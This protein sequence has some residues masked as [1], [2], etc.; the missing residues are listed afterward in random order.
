M[1]APTGTRLEVTE[2]YVKRVE[3]IVR[4]VVK[5]ADLGAIVSNIGVTPDLSAL[6]T[7]NSAMHTGF[8]EVGLQE[9]HKIGS[10]VYMD[11][12]RKR[13]AQEM[14]ELRTYFQSGGLVDSVLNQ[15]VPAPIDVQV[16]GSNMQ[17]ADNIA[18]DL[19]R[20]FQALPGI[21][22]VYIPQ[23]MDYPALQVNVNRERAAELG[24]DPKEVIDNL[25]TSLTSDA[26]ISPSYWVDPKT[27]NN[28]FVTVQ[29]PENQVKSLEDLKAMPLR[30]PNLKLPTYLNQV[31]DITPTLTP[32]E[33]DHYSLQRTI[34]VYV[35]PSGEDL[36]KPFK[37]VSKI[38]AATQIPSNIRIDLRGL[39]NTM[40]SSFRSFGFG[41]ALSI[42]LVYL[43]LVAQFSS[44]IDP[45]LI[46]LAI[47]TGLVGVMLTLAFTDTTL[48]IQSSDGNHHADGNGRFQQHFD[49]GF[50]QQTARRR[51][52]HTR[53]GRPF[54]PHTSAANSD[55]VARDR[56]RL[57]SHGAEA[58]GWQ[59]GLCAARACDYRRAAC[60]RNSDDFRC[61][62][63]LPAH[64]SGVVAIAGTCNRGI[65]MK[66]SGTILLSGFILITCASVPAQ[67]VQQTEPAASRANRDSEPS[68]DSGCN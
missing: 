40:N 15:G 4:Q 50:C 34:D 13:L 8:V 42:L 5:P 29:Y 55:D 21:S 58:R 61:S 60:L 37:E 33:V 26:M 52:K 51:S 17:A 38:I 49:R 7:P 10:Y 20:Q 62:C 31:A 36:G 64:L 67:S 3:N 6:S 32:T 56:G 63:C 46:V 43:A 35:S 68:S 45:F 54:L 59:R 39:V 11:E 18:L 16:S 28:Y 27:G 23:D 25:I 9:D 1:K 66:I 47:P 44:F 12:V 65:S 2:G 30:A 48:N 14:P 57:A 19:S 24:L 53:S 41:L 22:D